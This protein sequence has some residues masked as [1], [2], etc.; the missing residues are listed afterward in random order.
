MIKAQTTNSYRTSEKNK[1]ILTEIHGSVSA[2]TEAAVE[3]YINLRMR[4]IKQVM[5]QFSR[6]ELSVLVDI[7]NATI[8]DPHFAAIPEM[9]SYSLADANE[10]ENIGKKWEID[11]P[12]LSSKIKELD[13]ASC[14]FLQEEINR[15]W[16]GKGWGSPTPDLKAFLD[17]YVKKAD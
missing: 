5:A 16:Y 4:I 3:A 17:E 1:A 2:G 7:L 15:F 9:L 13:P 6:L 8:F 12:N 10:F 11:I 14:Y